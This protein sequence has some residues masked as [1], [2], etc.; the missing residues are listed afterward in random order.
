MQICSSICFPCMY[1]GFRVGFENITYT[2]SEGVGSQQVCVR[3]LEPPDDVT[4]TTDDFLVAV[5]TVEDTAG[6]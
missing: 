3:M 4:I 1:A 6:V 2:V 5:E